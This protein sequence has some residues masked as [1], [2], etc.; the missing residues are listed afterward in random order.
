MLK[1][2]KAKGSNFERKIAS[3][4]VETGL[5][6]YARRTPGS[7]AFKGI[8]NLESDIMTK[9]PVNFELKC[10]QNW[11]PLEYY[12]QCAIANPQP[13]RLMNVVIMGKNNTDDFAFL[14]AEDLWELMSYAKLGGWK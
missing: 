10:Q 12:K 1:R 13:G 7:G 3:R 5:D 8:A 11:S 14:K 4:L 6:K 9:L 2:P